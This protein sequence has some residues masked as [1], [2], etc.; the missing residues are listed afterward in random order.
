MSWRNWEKNKYW[1]RSLRELDRWMTLGYEHEEKPFS[2]IKFPFLLIFMAWRSMLKIMIYDHNLA[3]FRYDAILRSSFKVVSLSLSIK[4]LFCLIFCDWYFRLGVQ[5]L[6]ASQSMDFAENAAAMS[7]IQESPESS[8]GEGK[9]VICSLCMC[10]YVRVCVCE[11][12]CVCVCVYLY[13]SV[14][15]LGR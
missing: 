13:F 14:H 6:K 7:N 1:K 5:S 2:L 9:M 15:G 11:Y 10:V 4:F 12:V 8:G 3:V